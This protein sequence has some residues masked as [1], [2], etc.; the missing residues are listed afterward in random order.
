LEAASAGGLFHCSSHRLVS[1]VALFGLSA[2]ADL[3]P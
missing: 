1:V 3:S 2:M